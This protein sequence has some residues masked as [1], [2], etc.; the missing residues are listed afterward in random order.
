MAFLRALIHTLFG[1]MVRPHGIMSHFRPV[2]LPSAELMLFPFHLH[3]CIRPYPHR[4]PPLSL[5]QG[6]VRCLHPP[7]TLPHNPNYLLRLVVNIT[8]AFLLSLVIR[9]LAQCS[10][11][12][13]VDDR[14][15]STRSRL[16][17]QPS[18]QPL[19][20]SAHALHLVTRPRIFVLYVNST[21]YWFPN[22]LWIGPF[23]GRGRC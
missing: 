21:T 16:P 5:T 3:N 19:P 8:R 14:L 10:R 18:R 22:S 4:E 9:T 13:H 12:C 1:L 2:I 11:S 6:H 17:Y 15:F 7:L 20:G 23:R